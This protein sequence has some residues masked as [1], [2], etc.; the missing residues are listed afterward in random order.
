[1]NNIFSN[2]FYILNYFISINIIFIYLINEKKKKL[3]LNTL[4]YKE[5]RNNINH[6]NYKIIG[7]SYAN[8]IY[9]KQLSYCE[10]SALETGK[11]DHFYSYGPKD[12]D[13]EFKLSNNDI[14]GRNRGNGYWLWKPYFI[15]KTLKEKL[16]EGDYL[17][18]TDATVLYKN[19]VHILIEFLI[20][21]NEDMWFY[22]NKYKEKIYAKRDAFI[23]MGADN[24]FYSE[25]FSY[26][27]AFQI[28]KK[29]Q[30]SM[31]FVNDYLYYGKDKRIITDD[32][33]TLSINNYEGFIDHRH[34]QTILSLLIKKYNLANS[35]KPNINYSIINKI[36][37]E[38]PFIFCH[39]R[40]LK[41]RNYSEL[42]QL[43][44]NT[45][46]NGIPLLG[47]TIIKTNNKTI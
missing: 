39:Y 44:N 31:K 34:D 33:N 40:R 16:R 17:I 7:I 38:M 12:I 15:F 30:F 21:K 28:Y 22:K 47:K 32:K 18:Y 1:M 5:N 19:N 43:C 20:K 24:Q 25:T 2:K 35:G 6:S 11:V 13:I 46:K 26:N 37:S 41:F 27:A 14:L 8:E 3:I 42:K 4:N 45:N 10:K 9:S 36:D 29:S 23:L